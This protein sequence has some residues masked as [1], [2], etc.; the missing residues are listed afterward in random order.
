[1]SFVRALILFVGLGVLIILFYRLGPTNVLLLLQRMGWNFLVIVSIYAAEELLRAAALR[2]CLAPESR[3]GFLQIIHIRLIGEAVRAVTLTGP[4]L[5]EP[6]RAWLIRK[7]GVRTSEAMAAAV[8]EYSAN[9]F[10]SALLTVVGVI[11]LF[12]CGPVPKEL[13]LAASILLFAS[14]GYMVAAVAIVKRQIYPRAF[15]SRSG[16]L[17]EL[18]ILECVAQALL[19]VETYW[20]LTSMGLVTSFVTASLAEILTKL[21]NVAFVGVTEG[22]YAFLFHSLGLTAAAGFTLSLVK[23][24]RSLVLAFVGLGSLSLIEPSSSIHRITT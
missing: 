3:P 17:P 16:R 15:R 21:A 10:V 1:M 14:A 24:L 4:L 6:T 8:G 22:A 5:S 9:A 20:A 23:R 12:E 19:L 11:Y 18:M 7:Q 2:Q 13:R